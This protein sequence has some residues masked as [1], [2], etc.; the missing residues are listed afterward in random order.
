M[1]I[2]QS[3]IEDIFNT[4]EFTE[5]FTADNKTVVCIAYQTNVNSL[6]TQFGIDNG[7]SF[8]LTCKVKDYTPKKGNIITF[9]NKQYKIDEY[10]A[11]S[12]NLCFNIFLKDLTS[13]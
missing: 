8:Y 10:K 4:K 2:F 6:Y 3:A 12:F 13:K 11:D 5:Y 1:N 9:R 7:M